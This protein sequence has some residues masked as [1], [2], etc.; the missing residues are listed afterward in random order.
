MAIPV[1]D[2]GASYRRFAEEID[3]AVLSVLRR[4]WYILGSEC[5]G[6]ERAF[7]NYCG[8]AHAVGVANG[9]DAVE[10]ALRALGVGHGDKVVT[11][12]NTAVATVAA[13]ERIGAY[14]VFVDVDPVSQTLSPEALHD[15]LRKDGAGAKAVVAVHLFGSPCA[16]QP[17]LEIA[18][19]RGAHVIEDCAQAHGADV[20]GR[21]VGS[22]GAV[23]AFSFYPTKNLGAFGDGG[24]IVTNDPELAKRVRMLRQYGWQ[25]RY[26]SD[27][28]G[29]NSRLDEIQAAVLTVKLKALDG[30]NARRRAI[31]ERYRSRL[32]TLPVV[33]P[34]DPLDGRHVY[35]QFVMQCGE[36][37][38][39]L[40]QHLRRHEIGT[41]ILYPVPI[42]RQPAY[43]A[44]FAGLSLPVTENLSRSILS[45]P[46]YPELTDEAVDIVAEAVNRF[47]V[48]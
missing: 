38:D 2:P 27:V 1:A 39:E 10:L 28:V 47:Y 42:H 44:R 22:W 9:T 30:D 7:A 11:V 41:A 6:F 21:R 34:G 31:A 46:I 33:L 19:R 32:Q 8:V 36:C 29:V 5:E 45:L 26:V 4:G 16:M 25:R 17:I 48:K 3:A 18:G 24:A 15:C 40:E 20:L 13:I 23:G 14:P 35:H 43:H 12:A 37:R